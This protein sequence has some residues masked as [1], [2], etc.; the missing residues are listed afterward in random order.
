MNRGDKIF[1][2][3]MFCAALFFGILGAIALAPKKPVKD[4]VQ[5]SQTQI[6]T[7]GMAQKLSLSH[8]EAVGI[9]SPMIACYGGERAQFCEAT[10]WLG[11]NRTL[12]KYSCHSEEGQHTCELAFSSH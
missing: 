11:Q 9:H 10:G 5:E 1:F 12:L 4:T 6:G 2:G 3:V 7:L 8:M